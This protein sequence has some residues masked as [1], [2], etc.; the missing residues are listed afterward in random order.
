MTPVRDFVGYAGRPPAVSWPDGARLAVSIVVNVEEGAEPSPLDG[1][2]YAEARAEMP[3]Q[4]RE[5]VRDLA[6]ESQY[7]YGSRAGIWRILETLGEYRAPSTFFACG[8]ALERNPAAAAAIVAGGH[9]VCSHGYEWREPSTITRDEERRAIRRAVEAIEVT[10]G[11]RPVGWYSR[12]GPSV[13][14][15]ALL[16]EEGG[17]L[18]DSDASNDDLP[19]RVDV[20]GHPFLVL[21]YG[22]DTNDMKFW[23][24][25]FTTA[26]SFADYLRD[27]FDVLYREGERQPRMMSVGVHARILGRPGRI[28]ALRAFLDHVREHEGVWIA[29]RDQIARYWLAQESQPPPAAG[30]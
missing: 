1:D 4:A 9:E 5:G 3:H 26:N 12:W 23:L 14:T 6:I 21:P 8:R 19:Y 30:E 20:A 2:P 10:T 13:H 18:Y 29:R 24:G 27:S 28:P 25:G 15:R 17:F 22:M 11:T 16:V 7:E